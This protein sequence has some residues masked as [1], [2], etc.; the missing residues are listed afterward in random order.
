MEAQNASLEA[1]IDPDE[2]LPSVEMEVVTILRE[3]DLCDME[4]GA[5]IFA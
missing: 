4:L 5:P 2:G 3:S 1:K